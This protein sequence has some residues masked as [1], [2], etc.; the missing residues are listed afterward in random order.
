MGRTKECL[1]ALA[2]LLT[3]TASLSGCGSPPRPGEAHGHLIQPPTTQG[4]LC[5]K[6]PF[7]EVKSGD[8]KH[9]VTPSASEPIAFAS[10]DH[11]A[12]AGKL[13]V[14]DHELDQLPP[15]IARIRRGMVKRFMG[16][17]IKDG[18]TG[19]SALDLDRLLAVSV[20]RRVFDFRSHQS[21]PV[22]DPVFGQREELAFA[23]K[24]A[25]GQRTEVEVVKVFPLSML[26]AQLFVCAANPVWADKSPLGDDEGDLTD[27]VTDV[28]LV[29]RRVTQGLTYT[30]TKPVDMSENL[31]SILGSIWQH[32]PRGPQW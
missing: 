24:W 1:A 6:H 3:A 12:D 19:W 29:D 32:A 13:L 9:A 8:V 2:A 25:D 10:D 18:T 31:A 14:L 11:P 7:G 30:Y 27:G 23:R 16:K 22:T 26:E 28:F 17:F 20:E 5:E 4:P 21:T 15:E